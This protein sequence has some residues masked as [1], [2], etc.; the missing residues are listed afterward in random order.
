MGANPD[1]HKCWSTA[2]EISYI[3]DLVSGAV[4]VRPGGNYLPQNS[5]RGLL[6]NYIAS[7]KKRKQFKTF[8]DVDTKTVIRY[9]EDTL[10]KLT[11]S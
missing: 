8:G 10:E 1:W 3:N 7:A 9:A 2:N 6:R 11:G 4:F 5:T